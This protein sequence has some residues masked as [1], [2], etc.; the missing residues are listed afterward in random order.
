VLAHVTDAAG[1]SG[2]AVSMIL[3]SAQA[4]S[5]GAWGRTELIFTPRTYRY[6]GL[7]EFLGPSERGPWTL[8]RAASLRSYKFVT[9]APANSR[10]WRKHAPGP[11][12]TLMAFLPVPEPF[13]GHPSRSP[14][15]LVSLR[16][17]ARPGTQGECDG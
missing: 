12:G 7:Q 2:T 5:A 9:T 16:A 4:G 14:A 10:P 8:G 6:V 1:G 13:L 3:G 17:L 15:R 11:F